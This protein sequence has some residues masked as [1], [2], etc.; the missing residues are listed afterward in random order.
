MSI[1]FAA[2]LFL[3]PPATPAT[4]TL[5]DLSW[6]AGRWKGEA[7]SGT[8]EESWGEANGESMLGSFRMVAA[9]GAVRFYE[10]LV[11]QQR[12]EGPVLR[13]RHF[14]ADLIAWEEKD[15]PMMFALVSHAKKS[16][17]FE[18]TVE[19]NPERIVYS[20]EKETLVIRLEKPAT[21]EDK[22][23]REFRFR[24]GR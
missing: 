3:A 2:S 14:D 4:A 16:A 15:A 11:I 6:I 5:A 1:L 23:I 22:R 18:R 9:D 20:R 19:G 13:I 7:S 12:P 8:I 24:L 21:E 17:T 10:I